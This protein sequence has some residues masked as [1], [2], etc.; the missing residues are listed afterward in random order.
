M[1]KRGWMRKKKKRLEM[2]KESKD[3]ME[4]DYKINKTRIGK[5]NE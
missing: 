1:S 2:G 5:E 3:T 4:M